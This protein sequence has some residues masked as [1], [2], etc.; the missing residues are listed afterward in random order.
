V[1]FALTDVVSAKPAL[2]DGIVDLLAKVRLAD[3]VKAAES[4][5]KATRTPVRPVLRA[6]LERSLD[7]A[8]DR[9]AQKKAAPATVEA[10][11]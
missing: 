8:A 3:L 1:I 5:A 4:S 9:E 6:M 11:P 2:I 10:A 7:A